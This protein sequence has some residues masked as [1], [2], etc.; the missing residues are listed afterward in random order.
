MLDPQPPHCSLSKPASLP[1]WGGGGVAPFNSKSYHTGDFKGENV[2]GDTAT[3]YR[4]AKI[5]ELEE[6]HMI[7]FHGSITY[8][9]WELYYHIGFLY[10]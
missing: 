5:R 7:K 1:D 9:S 4:D 8:V 6:N 2:F 10:S 3:R